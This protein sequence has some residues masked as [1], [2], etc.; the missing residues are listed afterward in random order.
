MTTDSTFFVVLVTG[1]VMQA[2]VWLLLLPWSG[3]LAVVDLIVHNPVQQPFGTTPL[4]LPGLV[5]PLHH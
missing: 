1:A 4:R 5:E 3:A 2:G